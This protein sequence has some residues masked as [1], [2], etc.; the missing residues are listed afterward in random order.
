M[1]I[2]YTI[3]LLGL[4]SGA[5]LAQD[6][7][8]EQRVIEGDPDRACDL[9]DVKE[10]YEHKGELITRNAYGL[11]ATKYPGTGAYHAPFDKSSG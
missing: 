10:V 9:Y 3:A 8:I 6:S 1:R 4:L 11:C 7:K 5:A 2:I